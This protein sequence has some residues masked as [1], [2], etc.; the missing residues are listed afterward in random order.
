VTALRPLICPVLVGRDELLT[1][2][3]ERI[4]EV[5]EGRGRFVVLAGESGIGKTRLLGAIE[6]RAVACGL[7]TVRGGTYPSDLRVPAAVLLDL[8]RAMTR[9]PDATT[10][11]AGRRLLDVLDAVAA[12]PAPSGDPL[13]GDAHRRRRL[14]VLDVVDVIAGL[15]D[16]GP[17]LVQLE[18]LHWSD[19][20]TLDVL[21][22][23]ASRLVDRPL[24]VV[25]TYRSD[26]L[27]PRIPTRDWRARLLARRMLEEWPLARLPASDTATMASVLLASELPASRDLVEA[28]QQRSDGIPLH[29]EELIGLIVA[30]GQDASEPLT[31]PRP[32]D[33]VPDSVE[34][35]IIA[36]IEARSPDA[37]AVARAGAVIGRSFDLDLLAAVLGRPLGALADP[38]S[39]L[40]DQFILVPTRT[41]GRYGFRH[42]LICDSIYARMPVPERRDL[43]ARTADAARDRSDVG[44]LPFLALHLEQAGRNDEAFSAALAGAWAASRSSSHRVARDLFETAIRTA[45]AHLPALERAAILEALA[46]AAAASDDNIAADAAYEAARSAYVEAGDPIAAAAILAPHVAVRHLLGDD[47]GTRTARLTAGLDEL[48]AARPL[49][50]PGATELRVPEE[51]LI[52]ARFERAR[53]ALLAA[54]SAAYMLDR[55]LDESM[56]VGM[57]AHHA[58]EAVGDRAISRNAATTLGACYVFAGRMDDGWAMLEGVIADATAAHLESE[59][60]RAYRMLGSSASVLVEYARAEVWLRKGIDYAEH[61]ELWND[62]HYMSAHLAHVL[63]ATGRWSAAEDVARHTLADGRGGITTR[64]TALH[65]LGFVALG[66]GRLAEAERHLGEA[67][68][69]SERMGELQRLAPSLWGLAELA[70][71]AGRPEDAW[72]LADRAA[73]AC[74]QVSDAAYLFPVAVTGTRALLGLG[75]A[76]GARGWLER[77]A[78]ALEARAIPGTLPALDHARGVLALTEG[79]TGIARTHLLA[80]VAGWTERGRA[81]EGAWARLD[82]ARSHQR[83]NQQAEAVRAAA[84]ARVQGIDLGAPAIVAAADAVLGSGGRARA[85]EQVPWAP[86]TAREFDVA[87]AVAR[88]GTNPEIAATLGIT[89]KT[90]AAHVEHILDKLGMG[91][92]T[93]IA[94]WVATRPVLHSRP[95]HGDDR[96]E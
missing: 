91:R 60:A 57:V 62:R 17:A 50:G 12:T 13:D 52:A 92:R 49:A 23:L 84:Q 76:A 10:V 18:D 3:D 25:A 9:A 51:P 31:E 83:A 8:G 72:M 59:A 34:D 28:I 6:R 96:E 29:V 33:A 58:A 16:D 68:A 88:G 85:A 1:A 69:A 4:G 67:L 89:R 44:G 22:G 46:G 19:D 63:W 35:A 90:V 38:I 54:L 56:S 32:L 14:L 26:E 81:W 45:P 80:A 77:V 95:H 94:T 40:G 27:Y 78:A 64:I 2:T 70:L 42:A 15:A 61:A 79:T 73:T 20:L 30:A 48:T 39:E 11:L 93:E 87:R 55:R 66:R 36:R 43:H 41:P 75:D 24:L 37:V 7:R 21:E 5:L 65:A 47:L 53:A 86:L 82:L 74:A 71:A